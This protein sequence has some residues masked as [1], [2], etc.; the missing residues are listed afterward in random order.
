MC[1]KPR[2][3]VAAQFIV[4][5]CVISFEYIPKNICPSMMK[6][7]IDE[8]NDT[9]VNIAILGGCHGYLTSMIRLMKGMKVVDA[10][11]VLKGVKCGNRDTSCPDQIAKALE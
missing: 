8:S 7:Y 10:I 9:L 1:R 2:G 6:M 11:D 4:N 3:G 5:R